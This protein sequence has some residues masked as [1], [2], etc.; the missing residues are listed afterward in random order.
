MQVF[1]RG[2]ITPKHGWVVAFEVT[3][4]P[5]PPAEEIKTLYVLHNQEN[6]LE[7][8]K[9]DCDLIIE[10]I[11]NHLKKKKVKVTAAH[12]IDLGPVGTILNLANRGL[13]RAKA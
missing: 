10:D 4:T 3:V 2:I 13:H 8:T 11:L 7:A 1:T 9:H 12:V 6:P 5:P